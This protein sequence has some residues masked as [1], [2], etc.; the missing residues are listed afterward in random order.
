MNVAPLKPHIL[1]L[2]LEPVARNHI[3]TNVTY[4]HV[5][6]EI[7]REKQAEQ[8]ADYGYMYMYIYSTV[9]IHMYPVLV[10]AYQHTVKSFA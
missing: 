6:S 9:Y 4:M 5:Y 7:D 3:H 10:H 8:R 2:L 1:V